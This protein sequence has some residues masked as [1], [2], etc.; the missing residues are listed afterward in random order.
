MDVVAGISADWLAWS[1][2]QQIV[3]AVLRLRALVASQTSEMDHAPQP[4][5]V[6]TDVTAVQ[7]RR[8]LPSTPHQAAAADLAAAAA[9]VANYRFTVGPDE[10]FPLPPSP[11]VKPKNSSS[12]RCL[13]THVDSLC[14]GKAHNATHCKPRIHSNLIPVFFSSSNKVVE[15]TS[16]LTPYCRPTMFR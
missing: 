14:I 9:A 2:S 12:G 1:L 15:I 6:I 4:R 5:D 16:I 13:P 7:P 11:L 8:R 10:A 3:V